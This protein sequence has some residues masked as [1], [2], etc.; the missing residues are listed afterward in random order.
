M[1]CL[2]L[3]TFMSAVSMYLP[4]VPFCGPRSAI[5]CAD[6][7]HDRVNRGFG[8]TYRPVMYCN[9]ENGR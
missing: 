7:I 2:I 9:Q 4:D 8:R 1:T 3:I 6:E 5:D